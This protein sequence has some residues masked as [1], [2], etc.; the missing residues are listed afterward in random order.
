MIVLELDEVEL[1]YCPEC[2]GIWLD[3]NELELLLGDSELVTQVLTSFSPSE[4][5]GGKTPKCPLCRKK[6]ERIRA[7]SDATAPLIDRCPRDEGLWFD[8]GE[9]EAVIRQGTLGGEHKIATLLADI[10]NSE[11]ESL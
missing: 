3:A 9:L 1:D 6:M 10:F 5:R 8:H 7:G 4:Q 2:G 11:G